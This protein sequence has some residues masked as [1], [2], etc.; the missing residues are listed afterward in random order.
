VVC[1]KSLELAITY[2]PD[3]L[4]NQHCND[5]AYGLSHEDSSVYDTFKEVFSIESLEEQRL[6]ERMDEKIAAWGGC[7]VLPNAYA[8]F[9]SSR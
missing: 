8:N 2:L 9:P 6:W 1:R 4:L 5:I 7:D 3:Y